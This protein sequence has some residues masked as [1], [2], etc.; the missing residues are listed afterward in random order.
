MCVFVINYFIILIVRDQ[1]WLSTK[2][3]AS[4]P[5][6]EVLIIVESLLI[7]LYI[8]KNKKKTKKYRVHE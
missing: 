1:T 2:E 5:L 7:F 6:F 8:T 4:P 3:K